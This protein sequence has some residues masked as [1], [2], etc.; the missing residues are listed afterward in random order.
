MTEQQWLSCT[1]PQQMLNYLTQG[2]WTHDLPQVTDR[3]LR[4]FHCA[5]CRQLPSTIKNAQS[6]KAVELTELSKDWEITKNQVFAVG[7]TIAD[8][9]SRGEQ[10]I[11]GMCRYILACNRADSEGLQGDARRVAI[12]ETWKDYG[13]SQQADLLR[14]IFYNPFQPAPLQWVEGELQEFD[15]LAQHGFHHPTQ[16]YK[17]VTWLTPTV[18]NLARSIYKNIDWEAIPILADA[19]EEAGCENKEVLMHCHGED[20]YEVDPDYQPGK[21]VRRK[22]ANPIHV[23]GCWVLDL[24]LK[25]H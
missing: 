4:L 17:T 16:Y 11:P 10:S 14:E 24:L 5:C 1:E 9:I 23:R 8:M 13:K 6:S 20:W 18:E 12:I 19:L 25:K 2:Q 21:V 3:K 22:L 7:G 15:V